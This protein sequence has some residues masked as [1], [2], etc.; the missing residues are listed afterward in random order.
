MPN[1]F[2]ENHDIQF[3]FNRLNFENIVNMIEDNYEEAKRHNYAPINYEDAIEN[4]RKV[5]EVVG[6][7][8]GNFVAP[9]AAD[10]DHEG[11]Q[12][13]DGKVDYAKGTQ[14]NLKMLSKADLMGMV[15]PRQYG[16]LNFPFTVYLMATEMIS[17][18]DAS[19][20]NLFRTSGYR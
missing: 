5:L 10:V 19:L 3:H 12:Y 9:R 4:Y 20:M 1:F 18:A 15:L 7:I 14:E 13:K 11:A 16:G 17:R 6:D 2:T 8:A